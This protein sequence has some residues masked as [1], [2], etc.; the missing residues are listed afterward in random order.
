MANTW[1]V[2]MAVRGADLGGDCTGT[3]VKVWKD[4]LGRTATL[5]ET[6]DG[7][8]VNIMAVW[9]LPV[10]VDNTPAEVLEELEYRR[11]GI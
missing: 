11:A 6:P 5:V 8:T 1:T 4:Y 10:R 3:I 7:R 2:G 9:L